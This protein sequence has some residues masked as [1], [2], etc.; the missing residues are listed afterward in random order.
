MMGT[1][2]D[3][4]TI[5]RMTKLGRGLTHKFVGL[6]EMVGIAPGG[7]QKTANSLALAADCLVAGAK[8]DLF[9]PMYLMVARKPLNP[10]A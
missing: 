1:V 2:W 4:P 9:T 8:E 6:L 10:K 3:F 7:T 5:F